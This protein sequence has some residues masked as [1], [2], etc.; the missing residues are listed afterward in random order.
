M[1]LDADMDTNI[2]N[3]VC[4]CKVMS[5][6]NKQHFS[7]IWGSIHQKVKQRQIRHISAQFSVAQNSFSEHELTIFDNDGRYLLSLNFRNFMILIAR[8]DT[9]IK[10][11]L[12]CNTVVLP[13]LTETECK[14]MHCL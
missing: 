3:I 14:K 12:S 4:L 1:E 6:C 9:V 8:I 5:I 11:Q 13:P 10:E 2:Q 7:I